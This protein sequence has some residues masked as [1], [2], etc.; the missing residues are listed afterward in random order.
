MTQ[1]LPNPHILLRICS[2]LFWFG[3]FF[4]LFFVF[5]NL[6]GN[7]ELRQRKERERLARAV[8]R[9]IADW[10]RNLWFGKGGRSWEVAVLSLAWRKHEELLLVLPLL[11]SLLM[12][13]NSPD[14]LICS[15]DILLQHF[16]SLPCSVS[17]VS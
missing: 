1:D 8:R 5:F 14:F 4:C 15:T 12:Q 16:I 3:W 9:E 10:E 11:I 2:A 6:L 7:L 13:K 17:S